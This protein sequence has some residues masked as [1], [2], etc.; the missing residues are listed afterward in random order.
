MNKFYE[1][2]TPFTVLVKGLL[3]WIG[4]Y[5][6]EAELRSIK[7]KKKKTIDICKKEMNLVFRESYEF[8]GCCKGYN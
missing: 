7:K 6:S 2:C 3:F 8:Y 5:Q 4:M 1:H